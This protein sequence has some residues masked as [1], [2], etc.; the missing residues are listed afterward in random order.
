MKYDQMNRQ[1]KTINNIFI[2][3]KSNTLHRSVHFASDL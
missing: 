1:G 2:E 3:A